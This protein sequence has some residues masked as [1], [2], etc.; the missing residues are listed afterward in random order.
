MINKQILEELS[1]QIA[2]LLPKAEAAGEDAKQLLHSAISKTF[3]RLDLVT[4]EDFDAQRIALQRAQE[5][6]TQLEEALGK[7]EKEMEQ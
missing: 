2:T 3:E 6:I 1:A 5:R 4:R 7:L